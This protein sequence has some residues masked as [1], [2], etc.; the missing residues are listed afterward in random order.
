[1][2]FVHVGLG[3][4]FAVIGGVLH[5]HQVCV[6]PSIQ[7]SVLSTNPAIP[8]IPWPALTAEHGLGEN[9]QVNAICIFMAVVA[10]ILARITGSANLKQITELKKMQSVYVL[11]KTKAN[12]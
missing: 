3:Y 1:M 5:T 7:V 10:T 8:S 6:G 2:V 9:A 12:K 11:T 4:L